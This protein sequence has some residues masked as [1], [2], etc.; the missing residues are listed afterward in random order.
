MHV[1]GFHREDK[2]DAEGDMGVRWF[3]GGSQ[4]EAR[5]RQRLKAVAASSSL[6]RR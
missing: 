6:G 5:E 4:A 3:P 2:G 1:N